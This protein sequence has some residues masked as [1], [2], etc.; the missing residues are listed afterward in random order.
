MNMNYKI[1][2]TLLASGVLNAA[3][4][5]TPT[6]IARTQALDG[7]RKLVGVADKVHQY[8]AGCY[9]NFS[10]MP[11]YTQTMNQKKIGKA[12]FGDDLVDC[13]K[14][15]IQGSAIQGTARNPNAWLADYFYLAPD[16]N[17]EFSIEPRIQNILVNLDLYVGL[18]NF[19][20]G[21]YVRFYGPINWTKWDLKFSEPCDVITTGS[22]AAGYF[23]AAYDSGTNLFDG[24]PNNQLLQTFG[25][26]A[27]GAHPLNSLGTVVSGEIN[28][29]KLGV[30]FQGLNYAKIE[31]CAQMR[32]G[33]ADIRGELGWN[34]C[35]NDRG[36]F[37][38]NVQV[39][40]PSGS[41]REA[42]FAFDAVIGNGNHWEVGGGVTAHY[43]F[44]RCQTEDKHAGFYLDASVTHIN[45]AREQRTF[46]LCGKPNSRYM[47]A[48]KMNRQL[49]ESDYQLPILGA[50]GPQD[51]A[52]PVLTTSSSSQSTLP[53]TAQASLFGG[54]DPIAVFGGL[55]T[56][57]AN[58][59][60]LFVNVGVAVQADVALMFSYSSDHWEF[61]LGYNFWGRSCERI[62]RLDNSAPQCCPNLCSD[63][64]QWALKGDAH[65]FGF[66]ARNAA[67]IS[68]IGAPGPLSA[69]ECA[70]TIHNGTNALTT[71]STT[72]CPGVAVNTNCGV[73]NPTYAYFQGFNTAYRLLFFPTSQTSG[74]SD[75]TSGNQIQTSLQPKFINCC[76]INFQETKGISNKVFAHISHTWKSVS[77]N[78]YLGVG[79][80]GEWG[81]N[82]GCD[83]GCGQS[84][85]TVDCTT[86]C[87]NS[88]CST[89]CCS[90][91]LK[92]ALSQW[93]VWVKGGITFN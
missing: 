89:S 22:Y 19:A 23:N 62:T 15:I 12:L 4:E 7:S 57:V 46:D 25:A 81:S 14:I 91:C 11:E 10:V 67:Q 65:V 1:L 31:P 87:D 85:P 73:D 37:G 49:V 24:L 71:G 54:T 38:L 3:L 58:L 74:G 2:M 75:D 92:A 76:D 68:G 93:G 56:P 53:T 27:G 45:K 88:S 61:D 77:W 44:W 69:T 82:A 28:A 59:T 30:E 83:S 39:A 80:F 79:G 36:H 8:D 72:A 32:T 40:A 35:Q 52:A 26:Y 47:L 6:Y 33:F 42:R 29:P 90:P 13:N 20:K 9:V 50:V 5:V 48:Q 41:K 51:P 17:S 16:Y 34:F 60:T 64:D 43:V 86:P 78:P 21:L 18:D 63:K 55:F 70:A 84:T 66:A